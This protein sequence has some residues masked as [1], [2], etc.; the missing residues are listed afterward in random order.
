MKK[1]KV[2]WISVAVALFICALIAVLLSVHIRRGMYPQKYQE[3]VEKYAQE[4][5]VDVNLVYAVI[6]TESGFDPNAVSEVG[7]RGLMQLMEETFQWVQSKQPG[8]DGVTYDD[9]FDPE[10]NI[11]YG[12]K[13]L[14]LLIE[15]F[16]DADAAIAAYHGGWGNVK[17]WLKDE[18]YSPDGVHL[19]TTP[20]KSTNHYIHKINQARRAYASL[21]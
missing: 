21:Y 1:H 15:E 2:I 4:Y 13:L 6:R 11:R 19:E 20:L 9:M 7:A 8:D 12:T 10:T 18:R 3:H 16:G 14:S 5:Q 17:A